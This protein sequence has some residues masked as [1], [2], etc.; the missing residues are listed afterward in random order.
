MPGRG[1]HRQVGWREALARGLG[2]FWAP[3]VT[4]G[5]R[6]E[7]TL[8]EHF[9]RRTRLYLTDSLLVITQEK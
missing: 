1:H 7:V 5:L 2:S 3:P 4:R 9:H 6:G 8:Q